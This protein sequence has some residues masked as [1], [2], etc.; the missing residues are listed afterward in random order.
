MP[1][2]LCN[3]VP[4][5]EEASDLGGADPLHGAE[6]STYGIIFRLRLVGFN[7]CHL[8]GGSCKGC[9]AGRVVP[10]ILGKNRWL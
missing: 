8:T 7:P 5:Y 2:F 9:V 10:K 4:T 3:D 6:R 1:G